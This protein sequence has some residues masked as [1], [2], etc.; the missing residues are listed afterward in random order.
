MGSAWSKWLCWA[1]LWHNNTYQES[2]KQTPF[3]AVYG[4]ELPPILSYG[5]PKTVND[6][7]DQQ[8]RECNNTLAILKDHLVAVHNQMKKIVDG[9]RK[10]V[11]VEEGNMVFVKLRP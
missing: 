1:E 7:L 5:E 10:E 2:I 11:H 4:R 3:Q 8:L 9:K 6:T